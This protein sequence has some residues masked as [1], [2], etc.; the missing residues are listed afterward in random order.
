MYGKETP[1]ERVEA[2]KSSGMNR[3]T[4]RTWGLLFLTL[5]IMGRCILQNRLLGLGQISGNQLMDLMNASDEAMIF[6]TI[7]L[8]LQVLETCAVPIFSFLLVDGFKHT[9]DFKK[10]ILRV[11][12]V[13]VVSEIPYN[14]A[15]SGKLIDMSTRNPAFGLVLALIA[16]YFYK[17]Y[18]EKSRQNTTV[19]LMVTLAAII[20]TAMLQVDM[21]ICI[22]FICA[23]V[24][25][26]R[27]NTMFQNLSGATASMI[28][29]MVSPF[30]MAAPMGFLLVHFYNGEKGAESRLVNYLAYPVILLVVGVIGML[31]L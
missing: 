11:A 14:L 7:A 29:S 1:M 4:L 24:W 17:R 23:I 22:V 2:P 28:C 5:G 20:W 9:S 30:F 25:R 18:E 3:N 27:H 6:A 13:A 21:G 8:V 16:L 31:A 19:K 15:M 10:Y 12:G 26:F